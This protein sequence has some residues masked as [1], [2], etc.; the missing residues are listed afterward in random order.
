MSFSTKI[1]GCSVRLEKGDYTELETEAI[2]FYAREDLK[3]G[4]GYGNAISVRGGPQIKKELEAMGSVQVGE[5]VITS[6][7]NLKTKWVIHAAGPKFQEADT[8]AKLHRTIL[9]ALMRAREKKLKQ[10]VF[11]TMGAGFYGIELDQCA[12]V[13]VEAFKAGL[14]GQNPNEIVICALD[15]REYVPFQR[16]LEKLK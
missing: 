6:G 5:A 14:N 9:S 8:T 10:V 13:M 4:S 11:P 2:V 1:N 16:E 12:S 15:N 3:L 7:G